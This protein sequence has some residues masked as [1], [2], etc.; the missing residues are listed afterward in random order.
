M[1]YMY[2]NVISNLVTVFEL[3]NLMIF[4]NSLWVDLV[5][6]EFSSNLKIWLKKLYLFAV[7]EN[8]FWKG[9]LEKHFH[10]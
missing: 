7:S 5:M 3:A 2:L 6:T 10:S 4:T 1:T 8:K 9:V